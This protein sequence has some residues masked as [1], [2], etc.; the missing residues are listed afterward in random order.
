MDRKRKAEDALSSSKTKALKDGKEIRP[1][2]DLLSTKSQPSTTPKRPILST[3]TTALSV[4]YRGTGKAAPNSASPA[5]PG[6]DTT[7][8]PPKKGS[9]AEI[10][11]RAKAS[12]VVAAAVGV[13]KHK[14]KEALSNKKELLLRKKS[15]SNGKKAGLKGVGLGRGLPNNNEN[16]L[17]S[18]SSGA[19]K[20]TDARDRKKGSPGGYKGTA[21]AKPQPS[22]KGT[23]KSVES[24]NSLGHKNSNARYENGSR[25]ASNMRSSASRD[26]Y[27]GGYVSDERDEY[28]EDGEDFASDASTDNMEAGFSDVE[29]EEIHA[30]KSAKKED[31][32]QAQ[33][34]ARMKKEKEERK[35]RLD[36]MAKN[37]KKRTF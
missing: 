18:G 6:G 36:L 1:K 35:R 29:D 17:G 14:P 7:K 19:Q 9:Y 13:I 25:G 2:S 4:P 31:D 24:T 26:R 27:K 23:M 32:E 34:E 15:L 30:T 5:T 28:S 11:A 3:S 16:S 20:P 21:T 8:A 22:Y 10:M 37:A 33:I 12:H